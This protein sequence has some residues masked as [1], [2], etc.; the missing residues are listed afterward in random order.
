MNEMISYDKAVLRYV[1]GGVLAGLTTLVVFCAVT[2]HW[3]EG[4]MLAVFALSLAGL[5]LAIHLFFFLHLGRESKPRWN[6]L[7]LLFTGLTALM[8]IL[9]SLWIMMNLNYNMGMSPQQM[10]EYMIKQGKKG[11]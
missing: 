3:L 4:P 5:Q 6:A 11:F 7:S 9:G 1:M 8:I 10:N 2:Y